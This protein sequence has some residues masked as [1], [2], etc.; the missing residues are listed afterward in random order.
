M[1][2]YVIAD[3]G[4]RS[5]RKWT[6]GGAGSKV[7]ISGLRRRR[8]WDRSGI[9]GFVLVAFS[10]PTLSVSQLSPLWTQSL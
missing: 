2:S 1:C 7:G 3:E 10:P 9:L 8:Y 5:R 6:G 4:M